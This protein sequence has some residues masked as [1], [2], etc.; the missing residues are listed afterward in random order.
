MARRIVNLAVIAVFMLLLITMTEPGSSVHA[1]PDAIP[2]RYDLRAFPIV[3]VMRGAVG[4]RARTLALRGKRIGNRMDVFSKVGD[5]ITRWT[6]FLT[7]IGMG[8]AQLGNYGD[9][10]PV[11]ALF[12]R[13]AA[14]TSNSFANESLASRDAWTSSDVLDPKWLD[15]GICTP[16][17]TP[18]DCELRVTKPAVALIMIGTND[19]P[20]NNLRQFR[21]NLDRIVTIVERHYVI[22]VVSTIPYRRD[23]LELQDRVA[24]FNQVIVQVAMNHSAPIWNYWLAMESLPANGVSVDGIHPSL[25]PDYQFAIFDPSHLQFGFPMRNLTALQVLKSLMTV[26]Q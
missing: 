25:P 5:S 14:R 18:L 12:T 3:P 21:A 9:L 15:Q 10:Q 17:E 19:L 24:D 8:Q 13:E 23:H 22:P 4:G 11:I 2:P 16:K 6:Y 20:T 26:L 7:P 1:S